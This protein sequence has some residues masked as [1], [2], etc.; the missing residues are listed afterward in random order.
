MIPLRLDPGTDLK[1]ALQSTVR[2][3]RL[4]AA[5][6]MS[7]VG[8]LRQITLRLADI[9]TALDEYEIISAAGTLSA[10]GMHVHL[11]VADPS[12]TIL[13]GHLLGGCVVSPNGT[14]E[15]VLG[16][17]DDW[18]FTRSSHPETGWDELTIERTSA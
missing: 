8:S 4:S 12:G 13:G 18:R 14:V 5:W 11:A 3:E 2:R 9:H 1:Q 17:D 16:A 7:C 10:T 15:V 6:V